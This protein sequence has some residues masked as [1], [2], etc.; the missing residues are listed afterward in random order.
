MNTGGADGNEARAAA[1][2]Q[3]LEAYE[4]YLKA[5]KLFIE[6]SDVEQAIELFELAV[7][8]DPGFARAWAGLAGSYFV[9]PG[10]VG[11]DR[12]YSALTKNAAN[13]AI[14]LNPDLA[15]PYAALGGEFALRPPLDFDAGL[16]L[17]DEALV[18]NPKETS[19]LLWRAIANMALGYLNRAEQDLKRCLEFDPHYAN[20]RRHLAMT[21]LFTGDVEEAERLHRQGLQAGFAGSTLALQFYYLAAGDNMVVLSELVYSQGDTIGADMVDP[22]YT[23]MTD[24]NFEFEDVRAKVEVLMSAFTGTEF[25]WTRNGYLSF[26]FKNYEAISQLDQQFWW[27]PYPEEFKKSPARKQLIQ[28]FGIDDH[29]RVHGFPPQ[30]RAVGDDDFEC[31]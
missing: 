5:H 21:K 20:C 8:K 26:V 14:A 16:K 1:D 13:K 22:T 10:W 6:R 24:R 9:A 27:H 29:W 15:L 11:A 7:E 19:A 18:R 31:D 25:D 30:C 12:D 28:K 3:D 4:L 2:T 17:L 23:A